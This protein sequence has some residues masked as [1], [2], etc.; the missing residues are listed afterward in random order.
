M[1]RVLGERAVHSV[2]FFKSS[3]GVLRREFQE[4][5]K[6]F[7]DKHKKN[8]EALEFNPE[9]GQEYEDAT[10]GRVWPSKERCACFVLGSA[11]RLE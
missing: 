2:T 6:I 10:G 11:E 3:I 5:T 1:R 4:A 9:G 8:E 7:L